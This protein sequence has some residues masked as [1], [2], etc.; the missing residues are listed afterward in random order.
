MDS[1]DVRTCPKFVT[2]VTSRSLARRTGKMEMSRPIHEELESRQSQMR[3]MSGMKR[4]VQ[5][6]VKKKLTDS[7]V[8]HRVSAWYQLVISL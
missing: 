1:V 4:T 3:R 8:T 6:T 7:D 5:V 2:I